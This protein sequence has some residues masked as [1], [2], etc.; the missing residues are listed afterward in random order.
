VRNIEQTIITFFFGLVVCNEDGANLVLH[1]IG[2]KCFVKITRT[3]SFKTSK[4]WSQDHTKGSII[5][6]K[7]VRTKIKGSF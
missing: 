3:T 1:Q 2:F 7:R 5:N 4:N 6:K